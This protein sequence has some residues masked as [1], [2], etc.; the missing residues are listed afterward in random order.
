MPSGPVIRPDDAARRRHPA[1]QW[2]P[3]LARLAGAV[4][5]RLAVE[6]HPS[7]RFAASVLAQRGRLGMDRAAFA[8]HLGLDEATIAAAEDGVLP[9]DDAP[10][11]LT[12]LSLFD[13]AVP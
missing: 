1:G 4:A 9:R 13:D 3:D 10:P 11:A 7:P 12:R 2:R 5:D 6:G 8:A